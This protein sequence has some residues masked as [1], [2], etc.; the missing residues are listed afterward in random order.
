VLDFGVSKMIYRGSGEG[1]DEG[2][3]TKTGMVMGTPYYMSSEQARGER[4]LDGRV[5]VYACGVMM[6]EALTGK[7]PFTGKTYNALLMAILTNPYTP[8]TQLRAGLPADV[9]R[10]L[11]RA[12]ARKRDDRYGSAAEF[13]QDLVTLGD[14]LRGRPMIATPRQAI[15]A[16]SHAGTPRQSQVSTE[17][18]LPRHKS[19]GSLPDLSS[20][21]SGSD[22]IPVIVA[23]DGPYGPAEEVTTPRKPN[24]RPPPA[25]LR[26]QPAQAVPRKGDFD[27]VTIK[28]ASPFD[29]AEDEGETR[30]VDS[31]KLSREAA[32]WDKLKR[33][34]EAE[35]E[36]AEPK[37]VASDT[38]PFGGNDDATQVVDSGAFEEVRKVPPPPKGR[39]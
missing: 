1:E 23:L 8:A 3:L 27:D 29:D 26:V 38:D 17:Q 14:A 33:E 24:L 34:Q 39:R 12:M 36:G 13:Q 18:E 15:P 32:A 21:G 35:K 19:T 4:N 25:P 20:R 10:V 11:G 30:R 6:Y 5:D 37:P 16:A 31:D 22:D 2:D 7:R 28:Q 9:D